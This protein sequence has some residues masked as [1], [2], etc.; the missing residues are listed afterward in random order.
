MAGVLSG[1]FEAVFL[2]SWMSTVTL[3]MLIVTP[4]IM[5]I[6][7]DSKP[8]GGIASLRGFW[9]LVMVVLSAL[10]AFGQAEIPLL[11]LPMVADGVEA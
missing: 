11:V 2:T 8:L 5:F 4:V 1:N 3:G 7:Q 9:I 10:A 6:L